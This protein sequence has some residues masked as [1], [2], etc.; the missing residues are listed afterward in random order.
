MK[1][2]S[3]Q[4]GNQLISNTFCKLEE[5]AMNLNISIRT[6]QRKFQSL[7]IIK[8]YDN[9]SRYF[10]LRTTAEFNSFGI[11]E[12]DNI[13]FSKYGNLKKT[14]IAVIRY[15]EGGMNGSQI[16]KVLGLLP[17]SFLSHYKN[18]EEIRREKIQGK[19][20]YF[21]SENQIYEQQLFRRKQLSEP[22][23]NPEK[24]LP[25]IAI[26]LLVETIKYPDYDL[27]QL[28]NHV[29]KSGVAISKTAIVDFF[30]YHGLKKKRLSARN[31]TPPIN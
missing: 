3:E 28:H 11:W 27:E 25:T 1:N 2:L 13:H 6:V 8:S 4:I 18:L 9:N 23:T 24:M 10:A 20:I 12:H 17:R 15:S 26:T 31:I 16:G 21:S 19:Y 22:T 29:N 14:F 30:Q 7:E 5:L